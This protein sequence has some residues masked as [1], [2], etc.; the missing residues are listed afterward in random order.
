MQY[1]GSPVFEEGAWYITN[2]GHRN[3]T[4]YTLNGAARIKHCVAQSV[5]LE[6]IRS[7]VANMVGQYVVGTNSI[8]EDGKIDE[9]ESDNKLINF[10]FTYSAMGALFSV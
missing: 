10:N 6:V 9:A 7:Y 5:G 2:L 3:R 4:K 1:E 8:M